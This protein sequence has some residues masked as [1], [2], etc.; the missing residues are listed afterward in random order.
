MHN[1]L[2]AFIYLLARDH[3]PF[4]EIQS[5]LAHIVHVRVSEAEGAEY[6]NK[7]MSKYADE[8]VEKLLSD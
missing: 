5:I 7:T 4:G 1:K 3:M 6:T 2:K 8:V